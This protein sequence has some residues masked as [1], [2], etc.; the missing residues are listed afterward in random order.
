MNFK[1]QTIETSHDLDIKK[2][3]CSW[4]VWSN[5]D[6]PSDVKEAVREIAEKAGVTVKIKGKIEEG[7]NCGY[8][9]ELAFFTGDA[10]TKFRKIYENC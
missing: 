7:D 2:A 4:F 9:C 8:E 6:T 3:V 1:N 10:M 5:A